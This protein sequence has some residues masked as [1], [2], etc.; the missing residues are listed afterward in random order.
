MKFNFRWVAAVLGLG[1]SLAHN[2][3]GQETNSEAT[4]KEPTVLDSKFFTYRLQPPIGLRG[5]YTIF[6]RLKVTQNLPVTSANAQRMETQ[7]E[8]TFLIDYETISRDLRGGT[9]SR[10]IYRTLRQ[11]STTKIDGKFVPSNAAQAKK[12][13]KLFDGVRIDIKQAPDGRVLNVQGLTALRR[14][15]DRASSTS[16]P[17]SKA[18][19]KSI[20]NSIFSEKNLR[21]TWD[22]SALYLAKP[23]RVG[24]GWNYLAPLEMMGLK[25]DLHG[26]RRLIDLDAAHATIN[27]RA[28]LDL[29]VLPMPASKS[30][31][32]A[33]Q[34]V[35]NGSGTTKSK[36][37][38][39][40][41]TGME[42]ETFVDLHLTMKTKVKTLK[43]GRMLTTE[44]PQWLL[45]QSHRVF[46]AKPKISPF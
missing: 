42:T 30:A 15:L 29:N 18:L 40:R 14:R 1:F 28:N 39:N 35:V 4:T 44:I 34:I 38:V 21:Q 2:A 16:D 8:Q 31:S 22:N 45:M 10:L 24:D 26:T 23:V 11:T 3:N 7:S 27:D 17:S 41:E 6:T 20:Y 12:W 43:N 25:I 36:I 5:H 9:V 33:S 13:E 32:N 46:E 37:I 19:I